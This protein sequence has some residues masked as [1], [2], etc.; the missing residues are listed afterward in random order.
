MLTSYQFRIIARIY[1]LM[2][3]QPSN[4]R[5]IHFPAMFTTLPT[6]MC[7]VADQVELAFPI[8]GGVIQGVL[9]VKLEWSRKTKEG[10]Y[11]CEGDTEA[12]VD[13][14]MWTDFR[15]DIAKD[16]NWSEKQILP[17]VYCTDAPCL[18][19]A[20]V[21]GHAWNEGKGCTPLDW[22]L[23]CDPELTGPSN[24]KLN[25]PPSTKFKEVP[26]KPSRQNKALSIIYQH[27]VDETGSKINS[28]LFVPGD[29]GVD[30]VCAAEDQ[31]Q[32]MVS[33]PGDDDTVVN[34]PWPGGTFELNSLHGLECE[35]KNDGTNPGALF[36]QDWD[37]D[38][39]GPKNRKTQCKIDPVGAVQRAENCKK[40]GKEKEDRCHRVV[41][42]DW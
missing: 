10:T 18:R 12:D 26:G 2:T 41:T 30:R 33:A 8:N 17:F 23:G 20:L 5:F 28:W 13:A 25:C 1:E 36:C 27:W 14:M 19:Q 32:K 3:L 39:K 4:C 16:M 40:G 11:T 38:K 34:P 24:P 21:P 7:S 15:D 31:A 29:Y 9:N 42:C 37:S 22:P 6:Y 35:Y